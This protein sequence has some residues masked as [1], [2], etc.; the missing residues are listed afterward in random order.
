MLDLAGKPLLSHVIERTK[1]IEGV[2]SIVL[3]TCI[4]AENTPLIELAQSLNIEVFVGSVE[5]VLERYYLAAKEHNAEYVVRVTGDNP[6]TCPEYASMA[7]EIALESS[8]DLCALANLPL[9]T[10]VEIIRMES[11]GEAY[12]SSE[13]PYHREHV[14]PY[15]KEHPELFHIERPTVNFKNPFPGLRLTV[16]TAEDYALARTL[17]E[18]LYRG[19]TFSL[20]EV[21]NYIQV[22]PEL[23]SINMEV[24][25][26]PMT[27]AEKR[28]A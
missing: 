15:I 21:I 19:Q 25:Q 1:L 3:A 20:N 11:L 23:L 28:N 14:T 26:R 8:S 6:F 22:H 27:H 9:G 10:A 12:R 17:Y 4:G 16:D 18:G 24:K 2:N 5:N 13:K 7:V